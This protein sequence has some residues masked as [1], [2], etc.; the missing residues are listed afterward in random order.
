MLGEQTGEPGDGELSK[1]HLRLGVQECAHRLP[2]RLGAE[3]QV[4]G[5]ALRPK[6]VHRMTGIVTIPTTGGAERDLV[7]AYAGRRAVVGGTIPF[8]RR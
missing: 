8:M 2:D 1:L 3:L 6:I 5:G 7:Q 4:L